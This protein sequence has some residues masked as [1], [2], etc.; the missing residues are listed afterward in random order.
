MI[1]AYKLFEKHKG[2]LY[3]WYPW[4]G[5]KFEA[6]DPKYIITRAD[7]CGPFAC[8]DTVKN[9]LRLGGPQKHDW[10]VLYQVRIKESKDKYLWIGDC[11]RRSDFPRGTILADEFEIL[12]QVK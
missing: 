6:Y 12:E 5:M 9:A 10:D 2:K 1:I 4:H 3:S 8:F 11:K 7:D